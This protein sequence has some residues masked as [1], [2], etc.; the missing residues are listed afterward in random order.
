MDYPYKT[1]TSQSRQTS[2]FDYSRHLAEQ[3]DKFDETELYQT[4]KP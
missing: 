3:S 2:D 1:K 4:I